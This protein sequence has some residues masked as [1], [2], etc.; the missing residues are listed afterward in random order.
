MD[1]KEAIQESI[2]D[3]EIKILEK[4]AVIKVG[5]LPM[6]RGNKSYLSLLFLNLISN[7][8]KFNQHQ[9]V[10]EINGTAKNGT[11]FLSV[12]DNGIGMDE[13][14]QKAIFNAFHRLHPRSEYEG[15]GIGLAICKRITDVH[16]GKIAV[17]SIPN[18][19]TTFF[20]ELPA[21]T[22]NRSS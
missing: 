10:I 11:V 4:N 9:P 8:L 17:K 18:K 1:V 2:E 14:D 3:L 22:A 5:E 20:I 16:G 13:D 15:S 21:Y 12:Q 19:G 7:S 6:V